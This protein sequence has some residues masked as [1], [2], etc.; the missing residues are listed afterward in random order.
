MEKLTMNQKI[1]SVIDDYNDIASQYAADFYDDATDNVYVDKFLASLSGK[2]ILDAGCGVGEDCKYVE[3]KGFKAIGIDFSKGM[4]DIARQKYPKGNFQLMD[5][6]NIKFPS[7]TF[8]GIMSNYSL[9]HIPREQLKQV[10]SEFRRVLKEEG[11]ILLI[12]QEGTIE[13]M[14][15]EPYR[16]GVKLYMNYFT[17]ESISKIVKE[18][19]FEIESY[20]RENTTSEFELGE[21][22][23]VV[24]A[25]RKVR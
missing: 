19:G 7:N 18:N 3:Q 20:E 9:F 5:M 12:L 23:L 6:S 2:L 16:P 8:D 17:I 10:L 24:Y 11:R 15:D 13:E 25:K 1:Q 22:K 4:L 21:S 14:V